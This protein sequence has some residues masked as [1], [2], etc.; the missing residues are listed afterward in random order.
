MEGNIIESDWIFANSDN[1]LEIV[2]FGYVGCAT[3]CPKSMAKL[4]DVMGELEQSGNAPSIGILFADIDLRR[5]SDVVEK[6]AR[7][8]SDRIRGVVIPEKGYPQLVNDFALRLKRSGGNPQ[9]IYHTD[10]F[11]VLQKGAEG[12]MIRRVLSNDIPSSDFKEIVGN[13]IKEE[14]Q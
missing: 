9:T 3:V 8:F 5:K 7:Q 2:F 6:Y 4:A 1:E 13:L 14:L 12:W 10:H 11:F